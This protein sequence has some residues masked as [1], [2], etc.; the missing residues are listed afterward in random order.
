MSPKI[1]EVKEDEWE[2]VAEESGSP[3]EFAGVGSSFVGT[4]LGK[5]VIAPTDDPNDSFTQLKFRDEEGNVRVINAGYKLLTSFES[6]EVGKRVRITRTAD[7]PMSDPGKNAMKDY[8][9]DV[10]R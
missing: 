5:S 9:V 3:I 7:V 10:A 4:Y 1:D 6:I 8:R 2:T